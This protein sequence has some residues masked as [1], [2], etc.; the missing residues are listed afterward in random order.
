[1]ASPIENLDAALNEAIQTGGLIKASN[2]LESLLAIQPDMHLWRSN[3]SVIYRLSNRIDEALAAATTALRAEPNNTNFLV[4]LSLVLTDLD[5]HDE[6]IACLLRA[7]GIE[8]AHADAHL[9][10]AQTLLM[11]GEFNPGWLEYEWRHGTPEGLKTM[12]KMT[13]AHWNGMALPKGKIMLI[14]DQGYGDCVQFARY[15]PLVAERCAEVHLG[16]SLELLPA[17]KDIPGIT[18]VHNKWDKLPGHAAY[19]R[20]STLPLLFRT[21]ID[22]IPYADRPY[23]FPNKE[24]ATEWGKKLDEQVP[25]GN[26][27]V[28][29]VWSGRKTHANNSRRTV[30][31]EKILPLTGISDKVTFISIQKDIPD[32]DKDTIARFPNLIDMGDQ[33]NDFSDTTGLFAN[34]DLMIGTDTGPMHLAAATGLPVWMM[35]SKA[36]DWR[37]HINRNDSPWYSELRLFRQSKPGDWETVLKEVES[38]FREETGAWNAAD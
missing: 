22:T 15:I 17:L 30:R 2:L 23:I 24:K 21:T 27:R 18:E 8:P 26:M 9:A 33:L 6:A 7:I 25:K 38:A 13:S 29:L 35:I 14:G 12:P 19:C 10:L 20:L 11:F 32:L 16:A 5:R 1:M 36:Y 28:G 4:N 34:L 31:L 3:L 37:W